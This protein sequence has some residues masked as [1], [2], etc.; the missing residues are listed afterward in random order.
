MTGN[1]LLLPCCFLFIGVLC[2]SFPIQWS[3]V[4]FHSFS[5]LLTLITFS[6]SLVEHLQ[7]F[8]VFT[9]QLMQNILVYFKLLTIYFNH[10]QISKLLIPPQ[11]VIIV[12]I[13]IYLYCVSI[14]KFLFFVKIEW[15]YNGLQFLL[16]NNVS[17][18]YIYIHS[19]SILPS[20][21]S[22]ILIHC[23]LTFKVEKSHFCI[24]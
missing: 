7:V 11:V 15:I 9:I 20:I 16:H 10:I 14:N 24:T 17:Q 22:H 3:Y 5:V 21:T 1:D 4:V 6:L 12:T 13:Y 8:F 19:F 18:S 23:C 2:S